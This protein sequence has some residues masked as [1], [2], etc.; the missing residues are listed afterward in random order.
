[1]LIHNNSKDSDVYKPDS[2][3]TVS[4]SAII[5]FRKQLDRILNPSA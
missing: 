4:S 2:K 5:N 1:M 3:D